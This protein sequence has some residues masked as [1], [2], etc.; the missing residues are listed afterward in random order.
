MRNYIEITLL[1][2]VDITLNFL[3][4]KVYQQLHL[5]LVEIQDS[6]KTVPVGVA[7]PEYRCNTEEN[8]YQLGSKVRL[9]S[10][11]SETLEAVNINQWLSRLT[12]YVHVSSIRDVSEK[13]QS[14]AIFRR[15][16]PKNNSH[17]MARRKAKREG[18][19]VDQALAYFKGRKEQ[20][21]LAPF[22][23][24]KSL[25]SNNQYRLIILQEEANKNHGKGVFSTYGLSKNGST[26][27]SF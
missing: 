21:S 22:V 24:I 20:Y 27:P 7:F 1:P 4:E 3:W 10:P 8:I 14:Y 5:A 19:S 2:D 12:D 6:D 18:I 11:T 25:S 17:K 16:Q 13:N 26:V 9:F 23:R 15:S